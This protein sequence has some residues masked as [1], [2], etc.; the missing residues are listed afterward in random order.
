MEWS[1]NSSRFDARLRGGSLIFVSSAVE[2]AL[3]CLFST[4]RAQQ[5]YRRIK[6]WIDRMA[7]AALAFLG[8]WLIIQSW[9]TAGGNA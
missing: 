2:Q 8:L 6:R 4:L 7:G 9:W 5:V 1:W 3:A